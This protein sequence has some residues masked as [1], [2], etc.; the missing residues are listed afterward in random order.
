MLASQ[1]VANASAATPA[2]W[3][4][5]QRPWADGVTVNDVA[6]AGPSLLAAAGT[7][8][9]VAISLTGGTS[10]VLRSPADQGVV[11][12]LF[13]IAFRDAAQG[14]AVG[15][16]GTLVVTSDG[17]TT[18]QAPTFSESAPTVDLNDVAVAGTRAAAVGDAG[19]V[20]ESTTGGASWRSLPRPTTADLECVAVADDGTAVVGTGGR[21]VFVRRGTTWTNVELPGPVTSV[22]ARLGVVGGASP[23]TIVASS[24]YEVV[25][26]ADGAA[27][28]SLLSAPYAS[29]PP[30]PELTWSHVPVDELLVAGPAGATSFY[31]VVSQTWREVAAPLGDPRGVATTPG[32]SVAYVLGTDGR[33]AR[34]FSSA[35]VPATLSPSAATITAG[36][37]IALGSTVSI[38]APGEIV[39]ERRVA[40]GT[41]RSVRRVAWTSSDWRR[42]LDL[43]FSPVLTTKYRLRFT[44]GGTGPLVSPTRTVTV[45]PK[46]TP[47]KLRIAV[48]RGAAYRF[49]GK[50]FPTLRGEKVR[51]YTDRGG[52][53]HQIP[54][55]GVVKLRDG[56]RWTSRLF[57]TP[58]R[59]TYHLRARIDSTTR[60]GSSWSPIVTVVVR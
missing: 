50:V 54:I 60:H 53:W 17:G 25:G 22:T 52:K 34:T 31:D 43:G 45:R 55:G 19:V 6:A 42:L 26:N 3:Q 37:R 29:A 46:L 47:D 30:W 59:E 36:S 40:G 9:R 1:S 15:A 57:G 20:I 12:D 8:G 49:K 2:P 33:V 56:T 14:I 32:Q 7:E 58:K 16:A 27:F 38:A 24:G 10:W 41:W 5:V 28:S 21:D 35:R 11:A 13:G 51:L 48:S 44:Y 18:W 39:V 4:L 23:M